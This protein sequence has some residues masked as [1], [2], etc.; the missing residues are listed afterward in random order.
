ML[1]G[2]SVELGSQLAVPTAGQVGVDALLGDH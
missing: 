2:E 1:L